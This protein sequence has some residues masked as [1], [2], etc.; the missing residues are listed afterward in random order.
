VSL[1]DGGLGV[2]GDDG[3]AR[4]PD[5][6]PGTYRTAAALDGWVMD[7]DPVA[8]SLAPGGEA[9]VDVRMRRP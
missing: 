2:A 5:L 6:S 8:V 4:I 7:G 9:A 1:F 3:F